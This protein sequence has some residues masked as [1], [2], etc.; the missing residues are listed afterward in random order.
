MSRPQ[1]KKTLPRSPRF[2]SSFLGK[3]ASRFRFRSYLFSRNGLPYIMGLTPGVAAALHHLRSKDPTLGAWIRRIG[4]CEIE[5]SP[6]G[7]RALARAIIFQQVSGAAGTSI[8][9]RVCTAG[10]RGSFPKASWFLEAPLETLRTS[11]L[12]PQKSTYLRDLAHRVD[13]GELDFDHLGALSDEEVIEELTQVH[14]V[15]RWTAQMYLLFHMGRPNVLPTG[16]LGVRKG[17][18]RVYGYRSLP[19]EGTVRRHGRRWD[20]FCSLGSYYM[21]RSLEIDPQDQAISQEIP[22]ARS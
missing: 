11:G 2:G 1:R 8:Y 21:W 19:S 17:V 13:S 14:G 5:R 18:Q 9:R 7:F 15:G 10:G 4:P 12:S 20:P 22:P 6:G 3:G 16:D